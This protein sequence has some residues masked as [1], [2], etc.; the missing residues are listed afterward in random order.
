VQIKNLLTLPFRIP[1]LPLELLFIVATGFLVASTLGI[2]FLNSSNW[3]TGGDTS[4]HI[5]YAWLYSE[6]LLFSGQILPNVPEVFA[7]LPFLSYY[8][9]LPFIIIAL[10]SKILG[11]STGFKWGMFLSQILLPG[12]IFVGSRRWLNFSWSAAL[13]A[14]LGS[15]A[16][17]LQEQNSIWG[18]NLLSALSG[19][20]SYSYGVFFSVLSMFA[21]VRAVNTGRG[22]VMAAFLEAATGFS[23][24]FPLLLVGFSTGFLLLEGRDFKRTVRML[25]QGH[26]LAFCL[27]GGWLWP[28]LEMHNLTIPNDTAYQVRD[29]LELLPVALWPFLIGGIGALVM[30]VWPFA[31]K[32]WTSLQISALRYFISSAALASMAFLSGDKLGLAD[33][34]FFPLV[35]LYGVIACG[36]LFGEVVALIDCKARPLFSSVKILLVVGM[37]CGLL[38]FLGPLVNNAPHWGLWNN[39]GL[40]SKP[41]WHNL[42]TI[43]PAMNGD[44]W[45]PRILFEHDPAYNDIGSTRVLEALPMFLN[46]RPVLEGLYMESAVLGPAIYQL[47]S[48]VSARPSSPLARF[49]SG[50]MDPEFAALH[51][52]FLHSDT[53]L[54]RSKE[55]KTA[56]EASHMFSK[57]VES[58]P[59]A[60]YKLQSFDSRL[61]EVVRRPIVVHPT[62]DWMQDSFSWFRTRSLF[63]SEFPIYSDTP[64]DVSSVPQAQKVAVTE[65]LLSRNKMVFETNAVG[66]PHLIKIAYHP[67]WQLS[68]KGQLAIAGGG[69]MLV[70]PQEPEIRLS[71]GHTLVGKLGIFS[72]VSSAFFILFIAWRTRLS[73]PT[74]PVSSMLFSSSFLPWHAYVLVW[75]SMVAVGAYLVV[76]SSERIYNR[77]WDAMRA[78]RL[79]ESIRGFGEAL[80]LRRP[81]A[82][83]EEALFWL[84]KALEM[85]GKR[86]EAKARYKELIDHYYGFWLPESLYT[87]IVL[88][89]LDGNLQQATRYV[90][91]LRKEYPNN[92][93]AAKLDEIV[94]QD[95]SSSERFYN[96]A[97]ES[98]KR[99]DYSDASKSFGR[100]LELRKTD[101]DKE[102]ALFWLA[103]STELA[104]HKV[105][106]SKRYRELV[107]NYH[108]YWVPESLYTWMLLE[109][110][111]GRYPE[112]KKFVEKLRKEYPNNKWVQMLED[113]K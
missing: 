36:W 28:M 56:I 38:G 67:R 60:L 73:R 104:G 109:H 52:N 69:F 61:A 59:F 49:P 94:N 85:G 53:L 8:F 78:N 89:K 5:M 33:V 111:A 102:E 9:P 72:T 44:L 71:Y 15:L 110:Q 62:R 14:S 88:E 105:E 17:L 92:K 77:A 112:N 1:S 63:G 13:F 43:F 64:I 25:L 35:W 93:W 47:Q 96:L 103:K 41:Q 106:A 101:V 7:G 91:R 40:D 26:A 55:A 79:E 97:W 46:H 108:G 75:I 11:F 16:F 45:S 50:S 81:P 20:F 99:M 87:Y 21:W 22:W 86:P 34:R 48:E 58:A 84:A 113:L 3:P 10:L 107:D 54:L 2:S 30:Q 12:A 90:A 70:V 29:W 4:S 6:E 37:S 83:K 68:S 39:A 74:A 95:A 42:T 32:S 76:H 82:K 18:G 57:V 51:M 24:G 80:A 19:E 23:H 65:K 66:K 98:M 31:R 100:A 27:L